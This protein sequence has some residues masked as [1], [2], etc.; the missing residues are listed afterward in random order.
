MDDGRREAVLP[1]TV[2][3]RHEGHDTVC[4][5]RDRAIGL[6]ATYRRT[7]GPARHVHQ[8]HVLVAEGKPFVRPRGGVALHPHAQR[9]AIAALGNELTR[10]RHAVDPRSERAVAGDAG[11][12]EFELE[13][14]RQR[15]R[16]VQPV[17]RQDARRAIGP[18]DQHHRAFRQ[19]VE[20]EFREI[21]RSGEPVE[22]DMHQCKLRQV[23]ALH[24]RERRAWH[25][26]QRIARQI[27][28]ERTCEGGLASSEIARE[29]NGIATL[30]RIGDVDRKP[31]RRMLAGQRHRE[32]RYAGRS[33]GQRHDMAIDCRLLGVMWRSGVG[34][35]TG[36]AGRARDGNRTPG[37]VCR[38]IGEDQAALRSAV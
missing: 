31:L 12:T 5:M 3:H 16:D 30:Q 22:V 11:V 25:F 17:G 24:Q 26:H 37:G 6:A 18:F 23:V 1:Q 29:R 33:Q 10:R 7:V 38:I 2:C 28:D 35:R 4:Q 27:T 32:G 9:F 13:L 34:M 15:E 8:D 14:G 21:S 20:T 36:M 19:I